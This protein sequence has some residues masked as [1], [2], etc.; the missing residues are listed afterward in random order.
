M[1]AGLFVHSHVLGDDCAVGV[2]EGVVWVEVTSFYEFVDIGMIVRYLDE[3]V[4][5]KPVQA[6]VADVDDVAA[7][8]Q[9]QTQHHRGPH[10]G[11]GGFALPLLVEFFAVKTDSF[12]QIQQQRVCTKSS[13]SMETT[14][15]E[16]TLLRERLMLSY[17]F[18][19]KKICL[20][21]RKFRLSGSTMRQI[22]LAQ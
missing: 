21:L 19:Q 7:A 5:A 16:Q 14:K 20:K 11:G 4:I 1:R 12:F 15:K 13:T 17:C 2:A 3:A 6:A 9:Q 8:G 22:G 10:A 18:W